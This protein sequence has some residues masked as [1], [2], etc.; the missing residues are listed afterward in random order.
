MFEDINYIM[1]WRNNNEIRKWFFNS[2]TVTYE[3]QIMWYKSYINNQNE[4]M[5]IIDDKYQQIPIGTISITNINWDNSTGHIGRIMIG[6]FK[7]R[8][9]GIGKE[10]IESVSNFAFITLGLK[11]LYA[12]IYKDNISSIQSFKKAGYKIIKEYILENSNRA[13]VVVSL[14]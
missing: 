11:K 2:N 13:V 3:E 6:N 7:V 14:V 12:E 5:F 4:I 1:I 9:K 8:G 10:S